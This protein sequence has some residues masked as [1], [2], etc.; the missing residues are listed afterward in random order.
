M[1]LFADPCGNVRYAQQMFTQQ[2]FKGTFSRSSQ[3]LK[4]PTTTPLND[5]ECLEVVL[6]LNHDLSNGLCGL[7]T[8]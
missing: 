5:I 6:L 8:L 2:K 3:V 4:L 1:L 7:C